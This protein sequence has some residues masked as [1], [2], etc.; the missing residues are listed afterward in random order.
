MALVRSFLVGSDTA[1][2]TT[3]GRAD[4]EAAVLHRENGS[5]T[6]TL[7]AY[8]IEHFVRFATSQAPSLPDDH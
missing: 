7:H 3:R 2:E 6:H 4:G 5:T 1:R 8:I